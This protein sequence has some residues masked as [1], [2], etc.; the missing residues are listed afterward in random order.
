MFV[1]SELATAGSVG[2]AVVDVSGPVDAGLLEQ[3]RGLPETLRA[4]VL[5]AGR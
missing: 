3:L 1:A 2:Y 5:P 4:D